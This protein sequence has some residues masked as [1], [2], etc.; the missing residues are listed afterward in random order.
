MLRHL[1]RLTWKRKSRNLMLSLEI[2]LAFAI[3]FGI[4]AF[5]LRYWQLYREPIGFD[6]TDAWSVT[7]LFSDASTETI[8]P[9]TYDLLRRSLRELPEVRAVGFAT[10]APYTLSTWTTHF[11][12]PQTGVGVMTDTIDLSDD[13]AA[14]LGVHLTAGRWFDATDDGQAE[15]PAVLNRRMAAALFSGR[16]A[17]GQRFTSAD[18]GPPR[19]YRVVGLVEDFRNKG[20]FMTPTNFVITRFAPQ[21]SKSR[22]R[23][24]LL[25]VAPGTPRAF[26]EKLNQRL[27]LV[28][29]DW[30][31]E[32]APLSSMRATL[33]KEE[34]VPLAVVAVIAAFMLLMVAFGLFGVLWQNTTRRIPEIGLR[35][36]IGACAGDIYRQIV[37]EQLLLCSFAV[38][39]G[40]VLLVQLPLTGALGDSLNWPVFAGA[41]LLSMAVIY[42]LSF[43]C[44]LYPGWRA[45]R[46]DPAAALHYE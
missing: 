30:S 6:G 20:P 44:S 2:L 4:A 19:V 1:L 15:L 28:R 31:Y 8:T 5:G 35:R 27:K 14:A 29:N 10:H 43:V 37:F 40:L 23:T 36:A 16:P 11:K 18:P 41:A 25:K 34:L 12:S 22:V 7:M 33:L 38:A 24:I 32:I 3:V 39:V 46:L 13:V 45:S 9:D 17:L 21:T 26:E 42:L